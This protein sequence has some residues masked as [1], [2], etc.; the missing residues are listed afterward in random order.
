MTD[1]T[2]IVRRSTEVGELIREIELAPADAPPLPALQAGA[3][4][5]VALPNGNIHG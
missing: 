2:L 3:H 5:M 4:I 1:L